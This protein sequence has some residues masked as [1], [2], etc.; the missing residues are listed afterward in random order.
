MRLAQ[1][2]LSTTSTMSPNV[3]VLLDLEE[4]DAMV[5]V[6]GNCTKTA[7]NQT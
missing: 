7:E 5:V 3:M 2:H 6:A 1:A 4:C